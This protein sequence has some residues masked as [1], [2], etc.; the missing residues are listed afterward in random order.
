MLHIKKN[1]QVKVLAGRDRGKTGRVLVVLP[2][3]NRA[4]VENINTIR[5]H[6][7]PNP[8]RNIKG[9]IVERE[10]PVHL[11]NLKV[12]CPECGEA[13]RVG[14]SLLADGNKVRVCKKCGGTLDK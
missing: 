5:R 13:V 4:I 9:G 11:S 8:Q 6:T 3:K 12:I 10:S 1:D 2:Q 7:R 14:F